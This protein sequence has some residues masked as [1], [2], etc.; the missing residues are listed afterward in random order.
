MSLT[1]TA[2]AGTDAAAIRSEPPWRLARGALP[3]PTRDLHLG[4]R[5][6]DLHAALLAAD[7]GLAEQRID[8]ILVLLAEVELSEPFTALYEELHE[9]MERGEHVEGLAERSARTAARVI[10]SAAV[11][12]RFVALGQWI[13]AARLATGVGNHSFFAEPDVRRRLEAFSA[14]GL[15]EPW[16]AHLLEISEHLGKPPSDT[17]L[18]DL[19]R[20]LERIFQ[21][22]TNR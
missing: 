20:I 9:E 22:E 19:P 21:T 7:R 12:Q 3:P 13:E 10:E 14:S 1:V 5:M 17:H 6:I 2:L 4:V 15:P 8:Q 11:D 16:S 18:R